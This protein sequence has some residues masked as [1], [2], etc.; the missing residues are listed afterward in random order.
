MVAGQKQGADMLGGSIGGFSTDSIAG[1]WRGYGA[2][3]A[4]ASGIALALLLLPDSGA[5]A[6]NCVLPDNSSVVNLPGVASSPASI[7]STV[8]STLTTASTAFLLQ[9]TAFVGAPPNPAPYQ[10]GGGVWVRG[11]G[12][13]IEVKS[14]TTSVASQA[15]VPAGASAVVQ[16]TQKVH[17]DFGGV[18]LGTDLAR[19]NVNGW[20]V[21]LGTTVEA[22]GHLTQGAF[23]FNDTGVVVG[24]RIQ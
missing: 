13:E 6:Q 14:T 5:Q 16:C 18:Q 3:A 12:G 20:N 24:G 17:E 21:H 10:Q 8:A 22:Q 7:G 19:L 23:G 15:P 4:A 1:G 2:K 11:V 9:S